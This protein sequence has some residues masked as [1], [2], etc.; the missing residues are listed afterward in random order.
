MAGALTAMGGVVGPTSRMRRKE[1]I[2][3]PSA[4]S[5]TEGL[6]EATHPED[7]PALAASTAAEAASMVG[8]VAS[9][10]EGAAMAAEAT[11]SLDE[12]IRP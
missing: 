8:A 11:D 1:R 9:T 5:T 10:A 2:P 7:S 4:G 3:A 6:R 12:E